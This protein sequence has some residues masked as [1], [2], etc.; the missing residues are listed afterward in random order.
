VDIIGG[1]E[2][3]SLTVTELPVEQPAK[4]VTTTVYA[5]GDRLERVFV[6]TVEFEIVEIRTPF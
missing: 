6:F 2:T 1:V 4:S 3:K 5:P